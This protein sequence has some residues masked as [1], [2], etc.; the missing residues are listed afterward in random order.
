MEAAARRQSMHLSQ[1]PHVRRRD[2]LTGKLRK[3][4][5]Q[6]LDEWVQSPQTGRR[7]TL[8]KGSPQMR[9]SE[10]KTLIEYAGEG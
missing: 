2:V 10:G 4:C 6:W 8:V 3:G 7:E 5:L 9:Q 1:R